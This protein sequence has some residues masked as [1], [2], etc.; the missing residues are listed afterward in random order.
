MPETVVSTGA[1]I[2]VQGST[3]WTSDQKNH[4]DLNM[5]QILEWSDNVGIVKVEQLIGKDPFYKFLLEHFRFNLPTGIDL[6]SEAN[7]Q[8]SPK[9]Q[10]IDVATMAFGQGIATTPLQVLSAYSAIANKGVAMRPYVV[11]KQVDASGNTEVTQPQQISQ[12]FSEDTANKLNSMLQQVAQTNLYK[13]YI[14]ITNYDSYKIAGKTGTAQVPSPNGGYDENT[15]IQSFAGYFP[16]NNPQFVIL[17]KLDY[18]TK[19]QWAD[20]AAAP[21]FGQ[22]AQ[23]LINYYQIPKQ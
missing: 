16:A 7:W 21:T 18:P 17:V 23:F 22:I 15:T 2:E 9:P 14:N 20:Y 13:S 19:S 5:A 10:D 12:I 8:P 4:G 3:I 11:D 6:P 1:S